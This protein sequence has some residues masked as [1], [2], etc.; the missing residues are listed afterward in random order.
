MRKIIAICFMTTFAASSATADTLGLYFGGG[1]WKHDPSGSIRSS[2]PN[3]VNIDMKA[4][5]GLKEESESYL[6]MAFD[7]PIP[8]LPNIRLEKTALSHSGNASGAFNYK[9]NPL[10]SGPT[11]VTLDSLDTILYYRLLDNWVNLDLGIDLRSLDGR[12]AIGNDSLEI[13]ETIPMLYLAAQFD[14]PL[15]GLSVGADYKVISYSGSSYNDMRLRA[16]YEI[17]VIGFEAGLRSTR[18]TLDDVDGVNADIKFD[19]LMVGAFLH[20]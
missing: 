5:M 11:E 10:A 13:S 19:G 8:L 15:T 6:W 7:H 20:F 2:D 16:A 4:D 9:G 3:S 14:L 17:G 12:F 1:S 18:I